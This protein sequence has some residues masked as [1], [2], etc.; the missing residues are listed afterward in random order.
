V[1]E[2]TV[3][4]DGKMS[5]ANGMTGLAAIIGILGIGADIWWADALAAALIAIDV[6]KDG[7]V[8][9]KEAVGDLLDRRPR[10]TSNT[11]PEPLA[12][13]LETAL[14]RYE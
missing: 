14:K 2:K 5:K 11:Q 1:H 7:V 9:L 10:F 4:I 12:E 3:Y 13:S 6:T 8:N